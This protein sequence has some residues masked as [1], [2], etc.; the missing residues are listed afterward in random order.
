MLAAI[1]PDSNTSDRRG[2]TRKTES[3]LRNIA[4]NSDTQ[5]IAP[6][7]T[8]YQNLLFSPYGD[9][10]YFRKATD[11]GLFP[12]QLVSRPGP[13]RHSRR[14]LFATRAMELTL[15]TRRESALPSSVAY[16][17][18]AGKFQSSWG[19]PDGA[20]EK[21]IAG[22]PTSETPYTISWS[23]DGKLIAAAAWIGGQGSDRLY[24]FDVASGMRR[25]VP[26]DYNMVK[27]ELVWYPDGNG[28]LLNY[29]S[30]ETGYLAQSN[31]VPMDLQRRIL[32]YHAGYQ[33]L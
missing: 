1:S 3:W 22:G 2:R 20:A 14:S 7:E 33:R 16:N 13:R 30:N 18:E 5:V 23:P 19:T 28:L 9:Y 4:S 17:P 29:R 11:A 6:E 10:I 26:G 8:D 31:W 24:F 21:L 25:L 12:I 15:F 27:N 32:F